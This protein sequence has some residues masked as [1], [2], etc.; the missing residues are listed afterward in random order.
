MDLTLDIWTIR[1]SPDYFSPTED[2]EGLNLGDKTNM[3][4]VKQYEI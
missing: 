2:W 3:Q 1:G 4:D